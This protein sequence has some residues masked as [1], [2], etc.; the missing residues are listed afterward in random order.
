MSIMYHKQNLNELVKCQM[1]LLTIYY[2]LLLCGL[3]L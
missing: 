3:V 1:Y 2:T